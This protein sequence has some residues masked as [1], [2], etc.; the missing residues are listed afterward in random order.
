[1]RRLLRKAPYELRLHLAY[2]TI[3]L[4]LLSVYRLAFF[5]VYS[6]RL[7]EETPRWQVALAFVVGLRFDLAAVYILLGPFLL[8]SLLLLVPGRLNR[9]SAVRAVWVYGPIVVVI[10]IGVI[11]IVD[12]MYYE[13]ANKHIGYEAFAYLNMELFTMIGAALQRTPIRVSAALLGMVVVFFVARR[14]LAHFPYGEPEYG[15]QKR[16]AVFLGALV[17]V[18]LLIRGGPQISPLRTGDAIISKNDFVNNLGINGAFTALTDLKVTDIQ[19]VNRLPLD[20]AT[21]VVRASIDYPGAEFVSDRFPL[22]R[23]LR[24]TS[25]GPLPNIVVVVLEGWTGRYVSPISDGRVDGREVTPHF[26]RLVREGLFFRRHMASGGRTTNGLMAL[27]GGIPDRPGLTAVRTRQILNRF[28]GLGNIAKKQLGYQTL[29]VAGNDLAFNNK[30]TIMRHWGFDRQIGKAGIAKMNR[31]KLGAWGYNDADILEVFH[32]ELLRMHRSGPFLAVVHTITTH[33]PYRTPHAKFDIFGEH[34]RDRDYLNVYHY[35]DWSVH[36]FIE[37][38]RRSPYFANTIFVLA[39]D[40]THHRYLNYYE[41]RNTPLLFFAPGRIRPGL[42]E[43]IV[44]QLDV[45]PTILGLIGR[46]V[47]FTGMGR[48]LLRVKGGAAYFAYGNLFGWIDDGMF[49]F[50][51]VEGGPGESFTMHPPF[52]DTQR[53]R[54]E[55]GAC[56]AHKLRARAFLNMSYRLLNDNIIFP[57]ERE[58]QVIRARPVR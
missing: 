53:C 34:V 47:Y 33:Y 17:V 42:R 40:H 45:L 12:I 24:G 31:Y 5:L 52:E 18:P 3:A 32:E 9:V 11:S 19:K 43:D 55:E 8:L 57:E 54:K 23:R 14:I 46:E 35:A 30:R 37:R 4:G 16:G 26:N 1:M 10:W 27:F 21:K 15:W 2:T 56:A 20:T 48:D 25:S 28:S 49:Y 50:Q 51:S 29:F 38:A 36:Q 22:L 44:S 7:T 41:D 13:N 58:L 39:S 6:Y